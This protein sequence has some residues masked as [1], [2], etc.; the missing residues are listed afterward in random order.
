MIGQEY[1]IKTLAF[2][3]I[4]DYP[5]TAMEIWR[6][7]GVKAELGTIMER[8]LPVCHT[9]ESRYPGLGA[10]A[11]QVDPGLRR[12]DTGGGV[13]KMMN[14]N[15]FYFLP[16][17]KELVEKRR[18]FFRL[19][20]RKFKVARKAAKILRFIPGLKMAAVCNNF[21]Y[22]EESDI[23]FFITTDKN[24]LWTVRF[25]AT[26]LLDIFRLRARGK[27][28]AD[29]ICLSF[30]A[31]C[32][33][34]LEKVLLPGG[35]P[36]FYYWSVFFDPVYDDGGV[37]AFW[38]ANGWIKRHFPNFYPNIG[39]RSKMVDDNFLSS[40]VKKSFGVFVNSR[41]GDYLEK[42]FK[43]LQ[44]KKVSRRF[45]GPG[46]VISEEMIKMHENDRREYFRSEFEKRCEKIISD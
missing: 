27:R 37:D 30:Y 17:R 29:R 7:L 20:E 24:R 46:V 34:N 26:T 5:P 9:G 18:E 1:F 16:G 36:Y 40:A 31:T 10:S 12:D 23:D 2:L 6:F 3:D 33:C 41:L 39:N 13:L 19:S 11:K 45:S 14:K 35:D 8:L 43:S 4:F 38:Q 22:H 28:R 21:Y 42:F 44:F 32:D 15:G 25:W